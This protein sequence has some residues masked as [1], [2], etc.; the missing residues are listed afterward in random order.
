MLKFLQKSVCQNGIT[1]LMVGSKCNSMII[2]E[3]SRFLKQRNFNSLFNKTPNIKPS[4][5]SFE[6]DWTSIMAGF[7]TGSF[8][9]VVQILF[10]FVQGILFVTNYEAT[11]A[12]ITSGR[13][14][15]G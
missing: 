12:T 11:R 13:S 2:K 10:S 7:L 15:Y 1:S 5:V 8:V 14:Y 6:W 9:T 3:R 4:P